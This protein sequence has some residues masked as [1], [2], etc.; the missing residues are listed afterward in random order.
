MENFKYEIKISWSK[1]D[2][3]YVARVTEIEFCTAHGNTYEEALK[4]I[5]YAIELWIETAKASGKQ[6]PEPYGEFAQ[7]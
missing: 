3:I 4:N 1:I 7:L 2:R 6:I 5:E